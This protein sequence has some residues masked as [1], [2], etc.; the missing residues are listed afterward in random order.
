MG[1][2]GILPPSWP[3]P[4]TP[5]TLSPWM[6]SPFLNLCEGTSAEVEGQANS[7]SAD[8]DSQDH[9]VEKAQ[10]SEEVIVFM[11]R[12]LGVFP[13]GTIVELT[14]GLLGLVS[15]VNLEERT[16]PYVMMH[17]KGVSRKDA[18][19]VDLAKEDDVAIVHSVRPQQL[20]KEAHEYFFAGR[21]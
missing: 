10:L 19:L 2:N 7:E 13:P 5:K 6:N 16:K 20:P 8:S 3:L 18:R 11:V 21:V 1:N 14:T 4:L 9:M 12:A 15:S 17:V